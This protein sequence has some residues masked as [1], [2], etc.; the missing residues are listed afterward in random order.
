MKTIAPVFAIAILL[1]FLLTGCSGKGDNFFT[2][3]DY[4]FNLTA[5]E[6]K[7]DIEM[8]LNM[9]NLNFLRSFNENIDIDENEIQVSNISYVEVGSYSTVRGEGIRIKEIATSD[10]LQS[11]RKR[12]RRSGYDLITRSDSPDEM[13]L[14]AVR[15]GRKGAAYFVHLQDNRIILVKVQGS[16]YKN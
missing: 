11:V 14:L 4:I 5:G 6:F 7:T 1:L 16:I 12:L 8:S 3:R 9:D 15:E 2:V 13:N 10:N